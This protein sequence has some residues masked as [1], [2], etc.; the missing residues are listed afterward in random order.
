MISRSQ[1]L[2][3]GSL[4]LVVGSQYEPNAIKLEALKADIQQGLDSLEKGQG[5]PLDVEQRKARGRQLL[6]SRNGK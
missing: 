4:K 5:K 6:N 3:I 2:I 1:I